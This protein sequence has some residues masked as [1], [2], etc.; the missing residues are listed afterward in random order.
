MEEQGYFALIIGAILVNN[1]VLA[2]FLGLCPF[3]GVSKKL[4]TALGMC[5]AVLFVLTLASTVT[6]V[7]NIYVLR[8]GAP[9]LAVDLSYLR[10]IVFILVIASLV[11]LVEL[12]MQRFSPPLYSA[13]GIYLPL[14][15]TNCAV[16]GAALLCDQN[17]YGVLRSA[18]F[19]AA[20]AT[21]FALALILF[22]SLREKL[23]LAQVPECL[24]GAAIA[25]VTAGI[26]AMVFMGF[27]GLGS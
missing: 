23:E 3:F 15:T 7:I 20:S 19:G 2:R 4:S 8:E 25:F 24:R 9:W 1:F 22:S 18:V 5:G 14:I 21:G 11:Q 16:L 27:A 12:I 17:E 6:A 13:L 10:T 26:L